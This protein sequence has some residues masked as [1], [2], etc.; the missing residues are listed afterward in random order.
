MFKFG[1]CKLTGLKALKSI[2]AFLYV[3]LVNSCSGQSVSTDKFIASFMKINSEP[4]TISYSNILEINNN[5]GHLQGIQLMENK[6]G[7]Y[8]IM[9]GSSDSHSY[10]V[11]VKFGESDEVISVNNLFDKP[12]K[13]AG[14]FQ[15]FQNYMAVGIEDNSARD[16][17]MVCLYDIPDPEN[18][19]VQPI[20]VIKRE[21]DP[22]RSTAGCVGM[23]EYREKLLL[24]V[25]DWDT[26]NIDFY[27]CHL[28]ELPDGKF[29]LFYTIT[30]ETI[31][32]ESWIDRKWLP[33]QNINLF[34]VSSDKLF[35]VGMGQNSEN[36]NVADLFSLEE[37]LPGNF[38]LVKIATKKFKCTD[39]C[40]FKAG[41]GMD[42]TNSGELRLVS[43]GYNIESRSYLNCFDVLNTSK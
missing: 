20:A 43:C 40:T 16:K 7:K 1:C 37:D 8:A 41:A 12:F 28:N 2:V 11:V 32:K 33:Y 13:H 24:I 23:T 25:G 9:T 17:S 30:M 27:S 19:P 39:N 26:R 4:V 6:A 21:G 38:K 36:E 14:G 31:S 42:L 34:T 10:Y 22:L 3:F 18:P 15:V 35:L 5:G 29:D